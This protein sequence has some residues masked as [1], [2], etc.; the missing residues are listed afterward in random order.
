[1]IPLVAAWCRIEYDSKKMQKYV[2]VTRP[3]G[4]P[5]R[6]EEE[7]FIHFMPYPSLDSGISSMSPI[8]QNKETIALQMSLEEVA[9]R[10]FSMGMN[11]SAILTHPK[12]FQKDTTAGRLEQQMQ[13]L[14][15]GSE[16]SGRTVVLE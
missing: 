6:I 10:F 9:G 8:T 2:I 14:Y 11:P 12:K 15:G 1:M 3:K 7:D 16:K 4:T 13:Q 5:I